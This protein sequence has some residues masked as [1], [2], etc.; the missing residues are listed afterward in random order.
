MDC[1][2]INYGRLS[3][4]PLP[5]S[6]AIH[7]IKAFGANA[8]KLFDTDK[9]T[10][11]ALVNSGLLVMTAI[12]N[13]ELHKFAHEPQASQANAALLK[14]YINKNV[15]IQYVVVGNEA[16]ANWFAG[17]FES[18][19][20]PALINLQRAVDGV[21]LR[22]R[23]KLVVPLDLSILQVS[24][25]PSAGQFRPELVGLM[26]DLLYFFQNNGGCPFVVNLYPMISA[27]ENPGIPLDF[28]LMKGQQH[29]Y[30]DNGKFYKNLF[31]AQ[32]DAVYHAISKVGYRTDN[33]MIGEIGYATVGCAVASVEN[34]KTFITN[35]LAA[36]KQGTPCVRKPIPTFLFALF[37]EDMK[38]TCGG[39]TAYETSWGLHWRDGNAK[40]GGVR[41]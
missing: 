1:L 4:N 10:L 15:Q 26:K 14:E 16:T 2:G 19:I 23:V 17:K 22:N 35:Y 28:I 20:M 18:L 30:T 7:K 3:S 32:F 12:P 9:G 13:G 11:D 34:A 6:V 37:D 27:T 41:C 31:E 21:G 40:H 8:V 24:Y 33:I 38:D 29:G 39:R 25:P 36:R 5:H